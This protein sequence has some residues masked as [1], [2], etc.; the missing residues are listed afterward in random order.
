MVRH[1]DVE[2]T[3]RKEVF[4]HRSWEQEAQHS[5]PSGE[6]PGWPGG[7]PEGKAEGKAFMTVFA[8]RN[9]QQGKPFRTG[10]FKSFQQV[11]DCKGGPWLS[12]TWPWGELR[13]RE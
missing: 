2:T 10:S 9:G 11:L 13:P 6:A 8:E 12:G 3:V 4:T 7:R 1:A 5:G